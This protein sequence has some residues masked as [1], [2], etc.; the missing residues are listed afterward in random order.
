M[1]SITFK[2]RKLI[3]QP[4]CEEKVITNESK[5]NEEKKRDL[6]LDDDRFAIML[7]QV[8]KQNPM[9]NY[10]EAMALTSHILA[11]EKK[12]STGSQLELEL[13]LELEQEKKTSNDHKD[14]KCQNHQHSK[15]IIEFDSKEEGPRFV[16]ISS[17]GSTIRVKMTLEELYDQISKGWKE[18]KEMKKMKEHNKEQLLKKMGLNEH[19]LND[20]RLIL[21]K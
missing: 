11:I 14:E 5:K 15:V 10:Y 20:L 3:D 17:N 7:K 2:D 1:A 8:E 6:T 18:T 12:T 13:E 4:K 16:N 19:D 9:L 21:E